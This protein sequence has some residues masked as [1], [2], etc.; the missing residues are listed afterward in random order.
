MMKKDANICFIIFI[1]LGSDHIF[2]NSSKQSQ[3]FHVL[4]QVKNT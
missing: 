2:Y 1:Y 4:F 3:L